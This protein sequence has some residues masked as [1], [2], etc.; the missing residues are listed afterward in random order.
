MSFTQEVKQEVAQKDVHGGDARAM[1]SAL[2]QMTSSLSLNEHGL[3]L[4]VRVE[5]AAVA[6]T[7]YRLVKSR[8]EVAID[9]FVK[10]KMNL[11]KNR[12]YGLRIYGDVTE[13]LKDLGIYSPRGLLNKPLARIVQGENQARAYLAGA[14]LAAG[15]V[16]PPQT[17]NYHLEIVAANE[18]H[19]QFL[20][21][22]LK[23]FDIPA[24]SIQRRN[25]FVVYVKQADKIADF[26][27]AIEANEALLAFE[28]V[29]ISRDFS[30]NITR[31]N[32][33]DIAN[34]IKSQSAAKNQLAD[35][36]ILEKYG[37]LATLDEKLK[38]VALLRKELPEASLNELAQK[39]AAR[40]GSVV[41]KSGMKHRFERIHEQAKNLDK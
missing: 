8:Y 36:E 25:K 17:S 27:R 19:A 24:K 30:N 12:V 35:I 39:L 26:L 7:V 32:N 16:N 20:C 21:D 41:S 18:E 9:L 33:M 15:S 6:R 14:F 4:L 13:I 23:R 31:L 34:E 40:T 11:R 38:E 3:N 22:Q 2:I 29:R 37:R 10:K 1:L 5:N 28:N